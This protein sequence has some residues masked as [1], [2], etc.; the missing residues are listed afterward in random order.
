MKK[1]SNIKRLRK[2]EMA[3]KLY[4][5]SLKKHKITCMSCISQKGKSYEVSEYK[6]LTKERKS[7]HRK[8]LCQMHISNSTQCSL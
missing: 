7:R 1:I 4:T 8:K 6:L 3:V 5:I 2:K